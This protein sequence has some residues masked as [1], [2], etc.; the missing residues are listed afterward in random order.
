MRLLLWITVAA[1]LGWAGY[2][3]VGAQAVMRGL[4]A[5]QTSAKDT[6]L[7]LNFTPEINGFPNR[8]DLTL[9]DPQFRDP[10]SGI[11]WQA[12]FLQLFML[13]YQPHRVIAVW[14]DAQTLTVA[15]RQI[16]V[17]ST[18]MRASVALRPRA[19]LPLDQMIFIAEGVRI[20]PGGEGPGLDTLR[21]ALR[22]AGGDAR[23]DL[24]A[25]VLGLAPDPVLMGPILARLPQ[26]T[27]LPDRLDRLH[28]DARIRLDRPLDRA[29]LQRW[30]DRADAPRL[31]AISLQSARLVW[32]RLEMTASGTLNVGADGVLSGQIDTQT[33]GWKV[34]TPLAVAAGL[35]RPEVSETFANALRV[36]A[37]LSEPGD[38]LDAPLILQGGRMTFGPLDLGPAPRLR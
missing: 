21:L 10:A 15:G 20:G 37:G 1:A 33:T 2:W 13:S 6:G 22:D 16:A 28:L 36:L 23:Y 19:S 30:T 34:I 29:A 7:T 12:P 17:A 35:I 5:A 4:T 14:P 31:T 3:F 18:D 8:F 32:G 38:R 24:G 27:T 11:G 9:T 25:E 26:G